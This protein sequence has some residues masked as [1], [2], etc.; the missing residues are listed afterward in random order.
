MS[1]SRNLPASKETA[2]RPRLCRP[3]RTSRPSTPPSIRWT[4]SGPARTRHW[5]CCGRSTCSRTIGSGFRAA[6]HIPLDA[7]AA[8]NE[9]LGKVIVLLTDGEDNYCGDAAGVCVESDV[10]IDRSEA[11]MLAKNAGSEIFVIAAMPPEDV[12][13]AL[14][15]SLCNDSA[16]R[17][18]SDIPPDLGRGR[19]GPAIP[20]VPRAPRRWWWAALMPSTVIAFRSVLVRLRAFPPSLGVFDADGDKMGVVILSMTN[21]GGHVA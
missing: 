9:G 5:A 20:C 18:G 13:T 10:G 16:W 15:E 1:H 3:R 2:V 11:C 4:R 6:P 14:G 19:I 8:E 12:S 7:T 21:L 17:T